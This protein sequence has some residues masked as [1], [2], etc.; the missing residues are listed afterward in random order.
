MD[1]LNVENHRQDDA[2]EVLVQWVVFSILITAIFLVL[3][4]QDEICWVNQGTDD[5]VG[6]TT[7]CL[8]PDTTT[9]EGA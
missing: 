2:I 9:K 3:A 6:C 1:A 7:D 5:C 4:Y 8:E